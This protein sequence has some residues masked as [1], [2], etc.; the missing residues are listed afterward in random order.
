MDRGEHATERSIS[1]SY[2]HEHQTRNAQELHLLEK[3]NMQIFL[4]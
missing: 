3:I 1:I 4:H 2:K